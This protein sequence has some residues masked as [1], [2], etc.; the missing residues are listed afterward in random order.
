MILSA[1]TGR[2]ADRL[3]K[4]QTGKGTEV[5]REKGTVETAV[6][7]ADGGINSTVAAARAGQ[8]RNAHLLFIDYGQP[9]AAAQRR[10]VEA[11]ADKLD[12]AGCTVLE[13]PHV[14]RIE[15]LRRPAAEP[16]S[17]RARGDDAHRWGTSNIPCLAT[18]LLS[19]AVHL[20]RGIGAGVVQTGAS[21]LADELETESG[22]GKGTPDHRRE[23]FYYFGLTL[24]L[25]QPPKVRVEL[26]TP[27]IDLPR[28]EI[29]KLGMRYNTPYHLTYSC[30][31]R[32]EGPCEICSGCTARA[33]A[34]K[35]AAVAD[36]ALTAVTR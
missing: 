17:D 12:T 31:A 5:L 1:R 11:I 25:L 16:S 14:A 36:P 27:L 22:P 4:E 21:E 28:D 34:F 8:K 33:K 26:E 3:R 35:M 23:F 30:Q 24:E 2:L 13:L 7:L 32:S 19:T 10:A 9:A 29:I 6:I 20:A 15:S 18:T